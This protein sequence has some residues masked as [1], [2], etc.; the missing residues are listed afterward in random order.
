MYHISFVWPIR[1]LFVQ[2]SKNASSRIFFMRQKW[3]TKWSFWYSLFLTY[4]DEIHIHRSTTKNIFFGFRGP[5]NVGIHVNLHF[6]NWNQKHFLKYVW[7]R[8]RD[9]LNSKIKYILLI[10]KIRSVC[11]SLICSVTVKFS[12]K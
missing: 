10:T 1:R 6:E 9:E 12:T 8:K 3:N 2:F 11:F 4:A 7:A 5:Q